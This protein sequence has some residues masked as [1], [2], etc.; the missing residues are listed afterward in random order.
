MF[1]KIIT[2]Y[3]HYFVVFAVIKFICMTCVSVL[4]I[5]VDQEV[6]RAEVVFVVLTC[7]LILNLKTYLIPQYLDGL[8]REIIA[9][10]VFVLRVYTFVPIIIM[11]VIS[12]LK[13]TAS[14]SL[15][16]RFII[17]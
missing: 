1:L 14:C 5:Y 9:S 8:S 16:V 13:K 3:L 15:R 11:Y 7:R 17:G 12:F 2:L 4:Y 6:T 10:G